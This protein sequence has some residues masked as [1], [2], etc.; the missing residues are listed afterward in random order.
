MQSDG[1]KLDRS[2][3]PTALLTLGLKVLWRGRTEILQ[4]VPDSRE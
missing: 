3:T 2:T 1:K 4:S